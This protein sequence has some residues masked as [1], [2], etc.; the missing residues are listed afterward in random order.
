MAHIVL[1]SRTSQWGLQQDAKFLEQALREMNATR[2]VPIATIDHLDPTGLQQ[3]NPVDIQ[4]H[5]EVPCRLAWPWGKY[6]I[7]V[8][9]PEW[10][11]N[12]AWDWAL[13][14]ADMVIFKS[15]AA[16]A[17]FPEVEEKRKCVIPWRST[18]VQQRAEKVHKFVYFLGG[19]ANKA[20]AAEVILRAWGPKWP[21]LELYGTEEV[22]LQVQRAVP[23][24]M[25]KKHITWHPGYLTTEERDRIQAEAKY[26]VVASVGEGYGYPMAEAIHHGAIP[27]WT[28]LPVLEEYWGT[29]LGSMG[30]IECV[31]SSE[32]STKYREGLVEF[33]ENDVYKAMDTL[34]SGKSFDVSQYEAVRSKYVGLFRQGWRSLM[35]SVFKQIPKRSA[36]VPKRLGVAEVPHVAV[37]TLTHNRP[38]W[39]A[40][41]TQNILKA[42]YPTDHLVWVVVDDGEGEGRVDQQIMSFREK[43]P[44][45]R[46]EYVSLAKKVSVGEKRNRGC[47][48]ALA[49]YPATEVFVMMDDDDHYP[50]QSIIARVS[51]MKTMKRSCV[52]CSTIPMYDARRYIS[53][54][55]VPPLDLSPAERVSEATLTFTREFWKDR[56]FPKEFVAEGEAFVKGR[57]AEVAEI[58]PAGVIVSFLH[59]RN[60]TSRRVPENQEPNGCHYG[61]SD[62]FFTYVS[63]RGM[64]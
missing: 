44:S 34:L 35:T 12:G 18:A 36:F 46:V 10:W 5:L 17:L 37:V 54:M 26:H 58:P 7:V 22:L 19:S 49:A 1:F 61:F 38:K 29:L 33:T 40:N 11:V 4:I 55:N 43:T 59:G 27:L 8:V 51:A 20:K 24:A 3:P 25:K 56:G 6:N 21:L 47:A 23:G 9:N 50:A 41:M 14:E 52:Y 42:D 32:P 15:Q 39:F 62:E 57:E 13:K 63:E 31:P 48:A 64:D 16:A 2:M 53:A 60:S 45:L 30:R 28:R